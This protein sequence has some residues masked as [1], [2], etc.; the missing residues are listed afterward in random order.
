MLN[1]HHRETDQAR[2][3]SGW[4]TGTREELAWYMPNLR[5]LGAPLNEAHWNCNTVEYV[6]VKIESQFGNDLNSPKII[7]DGLY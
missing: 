1:V 5:Q 7:L 2:Q 3:I 6:P 4:T